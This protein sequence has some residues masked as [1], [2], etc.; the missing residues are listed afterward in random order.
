MLFGGIFSAL[1]SLLAGATP[2]PAPTPNGLGIFNPARL[3][4]TSTSYPVVQTTVPG[5]RTST[6]PVVTTTAP[7]T[8]VTTGPPVYYS[9]PGVTGTAQ[10]PPS[11]SKVVFPT[12]SVIFP[13]PVFGGSRLGQNA[14]QQAL[15]NGLSK[16]GTLV[17]S[18][19][20]PFIGSSIWGSS[21]AGAPWGGRTASNTNPY[22]NAPSTGVTRSYTFN[23]ARAT[24]APD[25]VQ[26]QVL[27]VNNQF[28]GPLIE[29]NWGDTIA[30]TVVNNIVAPQEGT[31]IHWH[32][33]LQKST[34]YEDG[35]PGIT[36][37]PIAPGQ[38]F[39]YKFQADSYGTSWW[40]SHYSAQYAGGVIGPIVIHGP[41][42]AKYDADLGPIML[43]DYYHD[44]YN[45]VLDRVMGTDLSVAVPFSQNNLIN[46]KNNYNCSLITDG[47]PCTPN[48]GLSK[49][50]FTSGK[51]Y[52]LRLIN[53][54]SEGIQ[55]FSLDGHS[56]QV[57]AYDFVRLPFSP[58][59]SIITFYRFLSSRTQ[60]T[61]SL[62]VSA[63][64]L[65][66]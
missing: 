15:T 8:A 57:M 29:A 45:T 17:A 18:K 65:M 60:L 58:M 41:E 52:R 32:G 25:G 3:T 14:L 47:T 16:L 50:Q 26:R 12:N 35:V 49:F 51:T 66:S 42:S 19:L 46:G 7:P 31:S 64:V 59:F 39:T 24:M 6:V 37:C 33:F 54:G 13:F 43:S 4:P 53:A 61:S 38:T 28:P 20:P 44:D 9:G 2:T 30:V 5:G 10:L 21:T 22:K 48:A 1:S 36:Q 62:S 11:L 27:V 40:H 56:M 23:V 63:S 55:R 34:E